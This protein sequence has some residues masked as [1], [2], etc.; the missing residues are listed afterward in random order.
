MQ[1]RRQKSGGAK[2]TAPVAAAAP[3]A[4]TAPDAA[5]EEDPYVRDLTGEP[6]AAR[7]R[8]ENQ[9][10]FPDQDEGMDYPQEWTDDPAWST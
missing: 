1:R 6:A 7:S 4:A 3:D 8:D 5:E 10:H 2:T 9:F